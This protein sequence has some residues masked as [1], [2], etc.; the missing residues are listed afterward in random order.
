MPPRDVW[1][2]FF[3]PDSIL[4]VLG[5]GGLPGDAVEFGCGY[6]TFTIAVVLRRARLQRAPLASDLNYNTGF[7]GAALIMPGSRF[8]SLTFHQ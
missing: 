2:G 4:E 1:E 7:S 8:E 5:C 6:G 3:E